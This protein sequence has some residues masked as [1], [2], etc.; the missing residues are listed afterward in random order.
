MPIFPLYGMSFPANAAEYWKS[1]W[2]KWEHSQAYFP[3]E[4]LLFSH[5]NSVV[6]VLL[7]SKYACGIGRNG[8]NSVYIQPKEDGALL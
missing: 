7:G 5:E 2:N 8:V 1:H 4:H 3:V 6:D